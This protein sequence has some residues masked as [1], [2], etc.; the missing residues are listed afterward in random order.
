MVLGFIIP[1]YTFIER[2]EATQSFAHNVCFFLV[3]H[4]QSLAQTHNYIDIKPNKSRA[5]TFQ[6]L[7]LDLTRLN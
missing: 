6:R 1:F 2:R 4:K 5:G 7:P 3:R